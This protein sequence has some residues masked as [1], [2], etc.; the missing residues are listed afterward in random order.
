[1]MQRQSRGIRGP[2][3]A[4]TDYL[5][6]QN[7]SASRI[8]AD[9]DARRAAAANTTTTTTGQNGENENSENN[10]NDE[11]DEE[12]DPLGQTVARAAAAQKRKRQQEAIDKIKKTKAY[13]K[14]KMQEWSDD[15]DDA[16]ALTM[17]PVPGQTENCEQCKKRFTVTAYSRTG[18]NGGLLCPRCS[19]ELGDE[20]KAVKKKAK[21][22]KPANTSAGRGRRKVQSNLL[23]GQIGVKALTTLCI[24]TLANHIDLADDLGDLPPHSID[25][26]ARLLSKRR[27]MNPTTMDLFLQPQAEFIN[28][29]DAAR[30]GQSDYMK[31]F[32][33]CSQLK[34]LKLRNAIQFQD[35]IMEF[36]IGRNFSLQNL[37]LHG[38]NLLTEECWEK[39]LKVKGQS[40]KALQIYFTDRHVSDKIVASLKDYAPSLTRLK[41]CHNQ[42]VSDEGV[43]SIAQLNNLEHLS[44]HLV[45]KT[46][47]EPYVHVIENIGHNLRTFS[48]RIVDDVDDRLLDALHNHCTELA[49]LRITHSEVMTDAGFARLFNDWKNKP[50]THIDLELCRHIDSSNPR[51][52]S[53]QIGLCSNGFKAL[54]KHSGLRL[55]KLNVHGCR[56]ISREAFEEVFS[57]DKVYNDL[58]D[59]EISFCE[60]VTDFVVQ[61]IFKVCPKLKQLNVFGCMKVKD[62]K[63]PR[64][65][66]LVGVP[67]ARGMIIEGTE[68]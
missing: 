12:G 38:A 4:L 44:L 19:K 26:V 29:Y 55:K 28:L 41:I 48:T 46:S 61:S 16:L 57:L 8:R 5:E 56:N 68:D 9:N 43:K 36:L 11:N 23:D 14:R 60:E 62:V 24:E 47:T 52:N 39:Y 64:G 49:K 32:Q 22:K 42:E 65:K 30:L 27:L 2:R 63:V 20:E 25:R 17:L 58:V 51:E 31:I 6:S 33:R 3:S 21:A 15:D 10:E 7:I 34:S 35:N 53:H 18:P 1:M 67:N 59:M 40:L 66:I 13:K 50:L 45:K 54:M 37:Y